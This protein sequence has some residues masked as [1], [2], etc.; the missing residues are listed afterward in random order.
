MSEKLFDELARALAEPLPRRGALRLLGSLVVAAAT[1][2]SAA[3]ATRA[4]SAIKSTGSVFWCKAKVRAADG[5]PCN[6]G[7]DCDGECCGGGEL[8]CTGVCCNPRTQRCGPVTGGRGSCVRCPGPARCGAKCCPGK[9]VCCT[10]GKPCCTPPNKCQGGVCRCPNGMPSCNG[11]DCCTKQERCARCY[12]IGSGDIS[13]VRVVGHK[14]CPPLS[15]CCRNTCC[16]PGET[17]CGANCC[18]P[19]TSCAVAGGKD[20]CCPKERINT[21]DDVQV[22]CPAGT[23][24]V[25]GGCCPAGSE[26]CCADEIACL[27]PTICING[28]CA[29]P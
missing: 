14:C 13:S 21:I 12:E 1:P 4:T 6:G 22:C 28:A 10:V 19:G 8:C 3:A 9:S 26:E 18:P 27:S 25:V 7:G 2:G 5:Q 24:P 20:V 29:H 23:V 17:C 15:D 16:K 11:K